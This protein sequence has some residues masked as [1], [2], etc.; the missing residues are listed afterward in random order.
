MPA[1]HYSCWL[2]EQP[3]HLVGEQRLVSRSEILD[4]TVLN[5]SVRLPGQAIPGELSGSLQDIQCFTSPANIIWVGDRTQRAV[6]PY[7]ASAQLI[8]ILDSLRA[9]RLSPTQLPYAVHRAIAGALLLTNEQELV[10]KEQAILGY[11]QT[12]AESHYV[13]AAQ[14]IPPFHLASL[15]RHYRALIRKGEFQLGDRQSPRRYRGYNDPAARY[16]HTQLTNVV[17]MMVGKPVK[18]S[19]VYFASYCEGADLPRH[20]DRAQCEY[21]ISLLI[22]STSDTG[23]DRPWP[24]Y[25]DVGGAEV[26]IEQ[27]MG[28]ALLYKGREQPHRRNTLGR[29][30][31]STSLFLHY[32]DQDFSGSL[33]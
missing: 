26:A 18:P 11:R 3:S 16:F 4:K 8:R 33:H 22:D 5:P 23:D 30:R 31:T 1:V 21:S 7:W 32:V 15:R 12:F 25:L 10:R 2:D 27:I 20:T 28:D 24:L 14:L 9:K 6:W 19:Y 29:G 13:T 17:S